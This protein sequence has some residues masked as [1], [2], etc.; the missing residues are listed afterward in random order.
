[1]STGTKKEIVTITGLPGSG[2]SSSAD[3]VAKRLGY[4]RFSSGDFARQ[5]AKNHGISIEEWNKKAETMPELDSEVDEAVRNA[6][7]EHGLVIDSRTAFHWI[8]DAF[9][10]FLQIDPRVAAE[11]TYTHI[12]REGRSSQT[13]NSVEEVYEKTL[14]RIESEKAR[15][16]K[17]YNL[18]YMDESQYDLI[19]DTTKTDLA[20]TV[21][22]IADEYQ[23]WL[24]N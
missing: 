21:K 20:T 15:Y 10:V 4:R 17:L 23:A 2:K 12:Q 16:L 24:K 6:G 8:P 1:M 5:V 7:N 22:K 19:V 11:R 9:K 3:G 18:N 14:A 13:G